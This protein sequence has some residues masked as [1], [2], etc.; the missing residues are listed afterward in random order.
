MSSV[1]FSDL[2]PPPLRTTRSASESILRSSGEMRALLPSGSPTLP[3]VPIAESDEDNRAGI[4]DDSD[5]DN[6]RGEGP[7]RPRSILRTGAVDRSRSDGPPSYEASSPDGPPFLAHA[8]GR[9]RLGLA[10]DA[11]PIADFFGTSPA[12]RGEALPDVGLPRAV[13]GADD[14][15]PLVPRLLRHPPTPNLRALQRRYTISE[16]VSSPVTSPVLDEAER[17]SPPPLMAMPPMTDFVAGLMDQPLDLPP[18]PSAE[19]PA[20]NPHLARDELR[21]ISAVHLDQNHPAAAYFTAVS[22]SVNRVDQ[23]QET[24]LHEDMSTGGKKVRVVLNRGGERMN[25]NGTGPMYIRMG[26]RGRISGRIQVGKVDHATDLEVA[27]SLTVHC[28]VLALTESDH[29]PSQH[30]LLRPGTIHPHRYPAPRT[31]THGPLATG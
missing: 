22:S 19:L 9:M 30:E 28:G 4:D 8:M 27:V 12:T 18:P 2:P 17:A 7:S 25:K 21:L 10:R 11:P 3:T 6:D 31:R 1:T 20:Y 24:P 15:D 26:R 23:P 16:G 13:N 5:N 14:D 29:R